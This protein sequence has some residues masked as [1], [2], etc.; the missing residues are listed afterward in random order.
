MWDFMSSLFDTYYTFTKL[1]NN[2]YSVVQNG[3]RYKLNQRKRRKL[4]RRV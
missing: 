1:F 3:Y 2:S 4:E